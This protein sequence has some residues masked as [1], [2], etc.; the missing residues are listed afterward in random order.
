MRD[1]RLYYSQDNWE[2]ESYKCNTRL[3]FFTLCGVFLFR[4]GGSSENFLAIKNRF[5]LI[6]FVRTMI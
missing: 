3:I 2:I 4:E 1:M 6:L 5:V